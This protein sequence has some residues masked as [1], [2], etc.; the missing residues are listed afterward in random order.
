[1]KNKILTEKI[2][3]QL[4]IALIIILSGIFL[5]II[6]AV[7]FNIFKNTWPDY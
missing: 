1:M 3:K 7:L 2:K 4:L 6:I 5:E